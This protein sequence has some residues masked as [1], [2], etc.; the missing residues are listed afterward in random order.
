MGRKLD[1]VKL[2]DIL[3]DIAQGKPFKTIARDHRVDRNTVRRLELSMD[4]Y[5]QPYPP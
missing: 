4:L 1:Q 2:R 3:I 5:A